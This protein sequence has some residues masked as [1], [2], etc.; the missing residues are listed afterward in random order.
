[1]KTE[2]ENR[3][4][5]QMPI[6]QAISKRLKFLHVHKR[7]HFTSPF[8]YHKLFSFSIFT[9]ESTHDLKKN[10]QIKTKQNL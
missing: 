8:L 5:K 9:L 3:N 7:T 1:M 10:C 4:L 6:S 2:T